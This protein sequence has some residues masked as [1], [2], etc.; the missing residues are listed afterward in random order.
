MV[1]RHERDHERR[2]EERPE[3]R[4]TR[5]KRLSATAEQVDARQARLDRSREA[6]R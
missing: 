5:L 1:E 4:Q 6:N 2:A 3:A